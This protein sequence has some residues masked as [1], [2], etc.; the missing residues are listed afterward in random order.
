MTE[1]I[2]EKLHFIDFFSSYT[3]I[4]GI[5]LLILSFAYLHATWIT[6]NDL[7][8]I[9]KIAWIIEEISL[10]TRTIIRVFPLS[11]RQMIIASTNNSSQYINNLLREDNTGINVPV[12]QNDISNLRKHILVVYGPKTSD[13]NG[14]LL[15][16]LS[17]VAGK[18]CFFSFHKDDSI[19][20]ISSG[21]AE[22]TNFAFALLVTSAIHKL[23]NIQPSHKSTIFSFLRVLQSKDFHNDERIYRHSIETRYL[24]PTDMQKNYIKRFSSK[25]SIEEM[26]SSYTDWIPDGPNKEELVKKYT[27]QAIEKYCNYIM[28]AKFFKYKMDI[29]RIL[30]EKYP[31]VMEE[32]TERSELLKLI[33]IS[34]KKLS[35]QSENNFSSDVSLDSIVDRIYEKY[36]INK[37]KENT[38]YKL[39]TSTLNQDENEINLNEDENEEEKVIKRVI[40]LSDHSDEPYN[41]Q[42]M[43]IENAIYGDFT[44]RRQSFSPFSSDDSVNSFL[45]E[46]LFEDS[47]TSING[48]RITRFNTVPN[49]NLLLEARRRLQFSINQ[50]ISNLSRNS[51]NSNVHIERNNSSS[52]QEEDIIIGFDNQQHFNVPSGNEESDGVHESNT[53]SEISSE[54]NNDDDNLNETIKLKFLNDE[55]KIIPFRNTMKVGDLK[56]THFKDAVNQRKMIRLIYSGQLCRDDDKRLT[57]Y[58]IKNGSVVHVHISNIPVTVNNSPTQESETFNTNGQLNIGNNRNFNTEHQS[59][60]PSTN[61]F[62]GDVRIVTP[63]IDNIQGYLITFLQTCFRWIRRET[64]NENIS[65][66]SRFYFIYTL[67]INFLNNILQY[68]ETWRLEITRPRNRLSLG[69]HI[70]NNFSTLI[71]FVFLPPIIYFLNTSMTSLAVGSAFITCFIFFIT[72]IILKYIY[73]FWITS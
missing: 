49:D 22:L 63:L 2:T 50:G 38:P 23:R 39:L 7:F 15:K 46:S 9:D 17:H 25:K 16:H 60:H 47:P 44:S 21:I 59:L 31:Q 64:E 4:I 56:K 35:K 19:Y 72:L 18:K 43:T 48:S 30:V 57:Y 29:T 53:S 40:H 71:M 33:N 62:E 20:D 54:E 32:E 14:K 42:I 26:I 41:P 61:N 6:R 37:D 8:N 67:Y 69:E 36:F 55:E 65:P 70:R 1:A 51:D 24:S 11:E 12:F 3:L 28:K 34:A 58:G 45:S 66:N 5:F 68:L 52:P 27:N 73:N 13:K 10:P